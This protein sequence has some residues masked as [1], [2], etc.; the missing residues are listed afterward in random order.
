MKKESKI[1]DL[2]IVGGGPAGITAGIYAARQK[3]KTL[4]ITKS[5]GGQLTL[6]SSIE[7][8]PGIQSISGYDL[9]K[10]FEN[11][12]KS[13][14]IKFE[15]GEVDEINKSKNGFIVKTDEKSF[16]CRAVIITSGRISRKLD[17]PG[18]MTYFGKGVSS[19]ATCDA[20]FFK[21]KKVAVAGTGNAAMN[22]VME[23]SKYA[24]EM[25]LISKYDKLRGDKVM[26]D[27]LES[28]RKKKRLEISYSSKV[29]EIVGDKFVNAIRISQNGKDKTIDVSGVFVEV[30][31]A[32]QTD[33]IDLIKKNEKGEIIVNSNCETNVKGIFAAGDCTNVPYKQVI[34]ASGEG[35]KAAL[36]AAKYLENS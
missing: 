35:A 34:I 25:I 30:G 20:P 19:C 16:P 24:K 32:P 4:M 21:D 13:H 6:S 7:N 9:M 33:F 28:L 8:W 36:S 14:D 22:I 2:I 17:V 10:S 1:Y 5:L 29:L 31:M 12:L 3:L 26:M 11:H 18:E 23:L 27:K 15:N